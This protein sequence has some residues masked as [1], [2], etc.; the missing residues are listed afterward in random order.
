VL[1]GGI[2]YEVKSGGRRFRSLDLRQLALYLAL[3]HFSN[4]YTIHRVG[5]YN[6]RE[7]FDFDIGHREF[8]LHFSGLST[9]ELCHRIGY[10]LAADEL[11]RVGVGL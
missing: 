1:A 9:E 7:G 4:Q 5:L 6:P 8:A 10:E 11:Y 2:L 3:N